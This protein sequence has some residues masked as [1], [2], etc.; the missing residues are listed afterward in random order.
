M[1]RDNRVKLHIL[2]R[3]AGGGFVSGETLGLELGISRAAIAKQIGGLA[4]W[5]VDVYRIPG[6]GYQLAAPIQLLDEA[7]IAN[8]LTTPVTLVPVI[9]STNQY[10]L[11]QVTNLSSGALCVAEYQTQGRGRRGR[12]WL[13]PF[14]SNL[15]MSMYWR[16]DAGMAAAMGLSLVVGIAA[17][18][19]LESLGFAGI[20]LKWPNDIYYQ[21]KKLAGIL[22][23]MSG[24]AGGAAHLVIGMGLNIAMNDTQGVID[25]PWTALSQ[26]EHEVDRNTL[27]IALANAWQ[28]AL[29]EYELQGMTPFVDKWAR[30]DNFLGRH[31]KLIMGPRE[32]QGVVKG[33]DVQGGIVLDT[34]MGEQSFVGG[35]ISLRKV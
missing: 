7:T 2:H 8:G 27:V 33:I 29:T 23:E 30:L 31:V 5:G 35:E 25:Q 10:L 6:R 20:K 12:Q 21:D 15:Y 24:Q 16:L 26:F 19:A 34:P 11:D 18:E 1:K 22:V 17:V 3:L 32:V 4:D 14:G 9:D 28:H 13:S